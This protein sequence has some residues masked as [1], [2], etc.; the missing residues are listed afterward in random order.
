MLVKE[1]IF[2]REEGSVPASLFNIEELR[3]QR[4]KMKVAAG[5]ESGVERQS[6]SK[7]VGKRSSYIGMRLALIS[8]AIFI[9]F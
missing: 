7:Q 8:L 5:L 1:K 2:S 9:T 6:F 4:E 3:D